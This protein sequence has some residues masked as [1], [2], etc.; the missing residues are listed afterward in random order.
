VG[1]LA[2]RDER[3]RAAA[4][5][6]LSSGRAASAVGALRAAAAEWADAERAPARRDAVALLEAIGD[7]DAAP[8]VAGA[9][10]TREA[11]LGDSDGEVLRDLASL[12]AD[13]ASRAVAHLTGVLGDADF[14]ARAGQMLVWLAPLSVEPLIAALADEHAREHATF[15]LGYVHDSRA[16]EPLCRQLLESQDPAVR[17]V[18]AWA[19][20][21]IRDLGAVEALVLASADHEYDVRTEAGRSFDLFGNVG[22]AVALTAMVP[23]SALPEGD[24]GELP[25]PEPT[26]TVDPSAADE[27]PPPERPTTV[28]QRPAEGSATLPG[29]RRLL[30]RLPDY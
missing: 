9:M 21:E 13:G 23:Q 12:S 22:M 6:A 29:L 15:A 30:K 16:V 10:L 14:G 26:E 17:R 2:D 24:G 8:S 4:L 27:T 11:P 1:A 7:A 5:G 18:S 20:G 3:V 19:L 25:E 28:S